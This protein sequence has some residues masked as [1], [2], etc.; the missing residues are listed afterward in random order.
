MD[1]LLI[2]STA[3][4]SFLGYFLT[5]IGW[6]RG[7]A[8]KML[9]WL[10]TLGCAFFVVHVVL[11][12]HLTHHWSHQAAWEATARQGGYGDG[13]YL[14]YLVLGVWLGDVL[15]WW[16]LPSSYQWRSGWISYP[17]QGFL[18]F[19]WFNAAVIFARDGMMIVGMV[20]FVVLGVVIVRR[21]SQKDA[22]QEV[23]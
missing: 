17:L 1:D 21:L 23:R 5:L 3:W 13:I 20:M 11:A 18:F 7:L 2:S 15:W 6:S 16:T 4:L 12:F 10:W 14:N 22:G 9:R 8:N 19:M